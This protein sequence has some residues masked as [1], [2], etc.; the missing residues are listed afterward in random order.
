MA[1]RHW[2]RS[3]E[4]TTLLNRLGHSEMYS[5][6]LELET[7]ITIV[8][9]TTSTLLSPQIVRNPNVSFI[10]RSDFDNFD[11]LLNDLCRMASVHTSHG[12]MLQDFSFPADQEVEGDKRN[13]F[14]FKIIN[15]PNM[16][17]NI[18]ASAYGVYISQLIRYARAS[19]NYSD[20]LKRHLYLRNRL[21]DQ[22]YK[23]IRLIR[24]L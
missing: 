5:F 10:F 13:D 12:I 7:S 6:S 21:L 17:S 9:E 4:I 11:Q 3:A 18:P 23:K 22:G 14:N 20:F 1:L 24:S 16:C 8:V 2:F 15:F 19:R